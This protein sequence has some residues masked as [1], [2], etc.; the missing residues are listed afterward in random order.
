MLA[1]LNIARLLQS[2]VG[3]CPAN[4]QSNFVTNLRQS[5]TLIHLCPSH[6]VKIF[7]SCVFE[8]IHSGGA[9]AYSILKDHNAPNVD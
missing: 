8:D 9:K 5:G 2:I 7:P 3:L 6:V 1:I 4:F